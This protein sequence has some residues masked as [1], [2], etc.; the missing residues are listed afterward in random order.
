MAYVAWG[1]VIFFAASWTFG[2][3][4][5]PDF[6]LKS[7][8][9]T[10]IYWW[11]TIGLIALSSISVY[12]LFWLMPLALIIPMVLMQA[13]IATKLRVNVGS[14]FVKSLFL[15]GPAV[16]ALIYWS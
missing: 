13:E 2:L 11:P 7:T 3:I 1:L 9:V 16:G 4:V 10:L 6:R 8:M 5:R 12:H 14:I 15:M